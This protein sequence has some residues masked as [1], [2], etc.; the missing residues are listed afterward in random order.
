MKNNMVRKSWSGQARQDAM[1]ESGTSGATRT[2]AA[3]GASSAT[4]VA[5][6]PD[7]H[8]PRTN[9]APFDGTASSRPATALANHRTFPPA[10]APTVPRITNVISLEHESSEEDEVV[11]QVTAEDVVFE[12]FKSK[13]H[14]LNDVRA[15]TYAAALITEGFDSVEILNEVLEPSTFDSL[16]N[17]DDQPLMPPGHKAYLTKKLKEAGVPNFCS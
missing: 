10:A 2:S 11:N 5:R 7:Q 15:R 9:G 16:V 12:W 17:D 13:A 8:T 4:N 14:G 6:L 1:G 3:P